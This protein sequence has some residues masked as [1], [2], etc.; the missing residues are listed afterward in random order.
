MDI[1]VDNMSFD[2]YI[3]TIDSG[4]DFNS[5]ILNDVNGLFL[6]NKE[7]SVL[8][9][10]DINYETC[11]NLKEVIYLIEEKIDEYDSPDDLLE[12]SDSISERDYYANTNK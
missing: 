11:N 8:K 9:D 2:E 1:H 12:I 10:Y 4:L 3:K 6:S 5:N 7:I